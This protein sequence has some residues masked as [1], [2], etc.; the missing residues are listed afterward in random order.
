MDFSDPEPEFEYFSKPKAIE[1]DMILR[2]CTEKPEKFIKE[3]RSQ[4]TDKVG[5]SIFPNFSK[6]ESELEL[7]GFKD[8]SI[9]IPRPEFMDFSDPEPE[10][11]YF[12]K[13]KGDVETSL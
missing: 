6:P 5:I 1:N 4:S 9:P 12:S 11:E 13:P 10:F 3:I 7:I 2:T 8:L